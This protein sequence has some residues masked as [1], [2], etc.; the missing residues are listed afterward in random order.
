MYFCPCHCYDV[1]D[2]SCDYGNIID[3]GRV[4]IVHSLS[5]MIADPESD[6]GISNIMSICV[7]ILCISLSFLAL[8]IGF[9]PLKEK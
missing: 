7:I 6:M 2:Y 5:V 8:N 3:W 1:R 4:F 9:L